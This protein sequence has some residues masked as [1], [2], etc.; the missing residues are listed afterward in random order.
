[1]GGWAV[2]RTEEIL[3]G[4]GGSEGSW[5]RRLAQHFKRHGFKD[6]DSSRQHAQKYYLR[7]NVEKKRRSIHDIT[8]TDAQAPPATAFYGGQGIGVPA[9]STPA[10][11]PPGSQGG[12]QVGFRSC[13]MSEIRPLMG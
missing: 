7:Q 2:Q 5:E 9:P 10:S 6:A 8:I 4:S 12:A 1:M 3:G 13:Y 11:S